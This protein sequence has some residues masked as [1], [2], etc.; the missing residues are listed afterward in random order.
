MPVNWEQ[1]HTQIAGFGQ[2]QAAQAA[3]IEDAKSSVLACLRKYAAPSD[4][5]RRLEALVSTLDPDI[6]C[7]IPGN[8][9]LDAGFDP[10]PVQPPVTVI[11]V[12]GSQAMPDRHEQLLFGLVNTGAVILR[13]GSGQ[14]PMAEINS[15]LLYGDGLY[16]RNG[17]R[18]TEGDIALL[19]DR[20]E[21]ASLLEFAR[22]S[23]DLTITLTDG[24]LE[25]W[26]AKDVSDPSGFEQALRDYL[27]DLSEL[28]RLGCIVAGYVDKPAADLVVRLFEVLEAPP[29]NRGSLRQFRP[30]RGASDRWLFGEILDPGQRSTV[31]GL[32]SSSRA[33]YGGDLSI[34]FFYLNVG[35][36]RHPAIARVEIPEWVAASPDRLG[37]LHRLLLEQCSLLGARPYPYVLHRAHE[38]ARISEAEKAQIRDRLLLDLYEAG[39]QPEDASGKATAKISSNAKGRY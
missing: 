11:A 18:L 6:R 7:A 35:T 27:A 32:Q 21:R 1:L 33:R 23:R 29:G 15:T 25:L 24:P 20:R 38:T 39:T 37:V 3:A 28:M 10:S 12:D 13:P 9:R 17:G 22:Q 19:R 2:K 5:P 31:L 36:E 14:A 8:E 26:G 4:L 34:H 30:F 16:S